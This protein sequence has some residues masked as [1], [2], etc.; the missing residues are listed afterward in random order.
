MKLK[1]VKPVLS[2]LLVFVIISGVVFNEGEYTQTEFMMDTMISVTA[3]GRGAEAA[4]RKAFERI[5]EIDRKFSAHN[6][7]SEL[8]KINS[9]AA[10][11]NVDAEVYSLIKRAVWFSKLTDGA[12]DVTLAPVSSL[13]AIGTE[14][15]RVP[16]KEEI[17]KALLSCGAEFLE[18]RDETR[19]VAFLKEGMALDLGAAAKGYA[20]E[21]AVR[22]LKENGIENAYLDLGGNIAVMGKKPLGLWESIKSM[23]KER[24][25]VVGIQDPEKSRGE[26]IETVTGNDNYIVTSGGYERC[27]YEG[28]KR[29]HHIMDG[30]TGFP[31][32]EKLDSVTVI[33]KDGTAADMISTAIFVMGKE[34]ISKI[35][36]DMY[37]EIILIKDDK[38]EHVKAM[39]KQRD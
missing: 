34:G 16:Q 38:T 36:E 22:V 21:E 9:A 29:Y 11:E 35:P 3:Y 6:E 12:F 10:T 31:A 23:K 17:E 19:T 8:F 37:E 26:I 25:F 13:W 1:H 28:E 15:Q 5:A 14:N 24:D 32:E 30:R 2:L 39:R 27:F 33:S 7:E 4:T 18:L 20:A